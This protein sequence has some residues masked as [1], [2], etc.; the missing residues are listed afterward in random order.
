[1]ALVLWMRSGS[2]GAERKG[3][4]RSPPN[5]LRFLS[6]SWHRQQCV[7][8]L[9]LPLPNLSTPIPTRSAAVT[10]SHPVHSN[11][12]SLAPHP[13]CLL[14]SA[15]SSRTVLP[16]VWQAAPWPPAAALSSLTPAPCSLSRGPT[17]SL[18]LLPPQGCTPAFPGRASHL[19]A[20]LYHPAGRGGGYTETAPAQ[21][22]L[23]ASWEHTA[24]WGGGH[25]GGLPVLEAS[26]GLHRPSSQQSGAP[27]HTA[28][29][30]RA[31]GC[32]VRVVM[33]SQQ[34]GSQTKGHIV[35]PE[36]VQVPLN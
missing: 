29:P 31:G 4:E 11:A 36:P 32:H 27:C 13:S 33:G 25:Q 22:C 26:R 8:F 21:R 34:Q 7:G 18:P 15:S 30:G 35:G 17:L 12:G 19:A 20:P 10:P 9:V 24:A 28:C 16:C 23:S 5:H 3:P 6:P 2:V 1:M 14:N